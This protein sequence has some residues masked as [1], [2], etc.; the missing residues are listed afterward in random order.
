MFPDI[1]CR[2]IS[3]NRIE[4]KHD[5]ALFQIIGIGLLA[6]GVV[7]LIADRL[8]KDDMKEMI[9]KTTDIASGA[10]IPNPS[11]STGNIDDIVK[12]RQA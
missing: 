9:E 7:M 11:N 4:M 8:V 2:K 3:I 1:T 12:G 5:S 10:G 6:S